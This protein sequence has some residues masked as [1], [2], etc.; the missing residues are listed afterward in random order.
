MISWVE[1]DGLGLSNML[2]PATG[3]LT[4]HA[5]MGREVFRNP[6]HFTLA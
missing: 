2:D 5:S 3:T 4:T 6:G 1:A